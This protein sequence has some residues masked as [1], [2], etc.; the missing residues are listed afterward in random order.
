M[1]AAE[2]CRFGAH[3]SALGGRNLEVAK[4]GEFMIHLMLETGGD[5]AED[6]LAGH[7]AVMEKLVTWVRRHW[8]VFLLI[9]AIW[10]SWVFIV[11]LNTLG[12]KSFA[13]W[14]LERHGLIHSRSPA[15]TRDKAE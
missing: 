9:A 10:M 11:D 5:R 3:R 4:A 13:E 8:H 15:E 1:R 14:L 12:G 6:L 2:L 7:G